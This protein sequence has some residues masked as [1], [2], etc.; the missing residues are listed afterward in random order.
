MLEI[1][2]EFLAFAS[3]ASSCSLFFFSEAAVGSDSD[4]MGGLPM[5]TVGS[6]PCRALDDHVEQLK[7]VGTSCW[8]ADHS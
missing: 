3:H 6:P 7:F 4:K 5:L 8:P 2:T 1:V